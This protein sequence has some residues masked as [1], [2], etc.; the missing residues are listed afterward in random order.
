[1]RRKLIDIFVEWF[2]FL[3][4][5]GLAVFIVVLFVVLAVSQIKGVT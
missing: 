4:I 3:S 1:M 2:V 5:L